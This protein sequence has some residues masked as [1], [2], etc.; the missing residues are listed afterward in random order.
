MTLRLW[1]YFQKTAHKRIIMTMDV[2]ALDFKKSPIKR[3][4][5]SKE[6]VF[7]GNAFPSYGWFRLGLSCRV[8]AAENL[9][10]VLYVLF[11]IKIDPTNVA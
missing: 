11:Q 4:R 5:F 2:P 3:L 6:K 7:Q 9:V 1:P 10:L 8:P